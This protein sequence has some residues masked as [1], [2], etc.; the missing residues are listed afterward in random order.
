[1][2]DN[3]RLSTL[4]ALAAF[5]GSGA[6]AADSSAAPP[7]NSC[8]F[9]RDFE[10]WKA[11]DAKT[12]Y[13]RV[14]LRRYF[15]LDM[16]GKC[17]DLTSP[18]AYLVTIFRGSDTICTALDWDLKVATQGINVPVG[19]IVKTMTELSPAEVAAIPPKFKP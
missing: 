17:P 15:R 13:I 2:R 16:A 5:A 10:S 19:C 3:L 1:M 12:I 11:P 7:S 9:S 4:I 6:W 8:F 14:G 18:D